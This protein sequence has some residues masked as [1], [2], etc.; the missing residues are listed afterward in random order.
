MEDQGTPAGHHLNL[1][2]LAQ[3][4]GSHPSMHLRRNGTKYWRS[5]YMKKEHLGENKT[6]Q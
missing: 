6:Q 4:E 2:C 1:V 5:S 3:P